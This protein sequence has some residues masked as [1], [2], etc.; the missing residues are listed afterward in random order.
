[1]MEQ[2]GSPAT[3]EAIARS[4]DKAIHNDA[5][6]RMIATEINALAKATGQRKVLASAAREYAAAMIARLRVRDI[7]LGQYASAEARAAGGAEG[8]PVGRPRHGGGRATGW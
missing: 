8:Q 3:P 4:A 6:A 5:R 7:R 2:F 1:M